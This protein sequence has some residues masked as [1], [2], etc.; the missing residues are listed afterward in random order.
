MVSWARSMATISSWIRSFSARVRFK[1]FAL[2][3]QLLKCS[4][5]FSSS[6]WVRCCFSIISLQPACFV[7]RLLKSSRE[8]PDLRLRLGNHIAELRKFPH[9][10]PE[11]V[12]RIL[13]HGGIAQM[14]RE[15][16]E[17]SSAEVLSNNPVILF[18]FLADDQGDDK[19][20]HSRRCSRAA[21]RKIGGEVEIS[22]CRREPPV[23]RFR[24]PR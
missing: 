7:W 16:R 4:N 12:H 22:E 14:S 21:D 18:I 23:P 2:F 1:A 24:E 5:F 15:Q 13:G 11:R 19:E 3:L 8:L 20:E 9:S 10:R 17:P 6:H